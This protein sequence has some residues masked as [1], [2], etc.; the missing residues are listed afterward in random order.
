MPSL[1]LSSSG[2]SL[3]LGCSVPEVV[4][5][6][7]AWVIAGEPTQVDITHSYGINGSLP[8]DVSTSW[9]VNALLIAQSENIFFIQR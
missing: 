1:C 4:S 8:V 5:L 9:G 6:T 7:T 2:A 3:V